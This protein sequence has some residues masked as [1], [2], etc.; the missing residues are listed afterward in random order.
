VDVSKF[1]KSYI[2]KGW[3]RRK[4]FDVTSQHQTLLEVE[5]ALNNTEILYSWPA[6]N[7]EVYHHNEA[8]FEHQEYGSV[9]PPLRNESTHGSLPWLA[10]QREIARLVFVSIKSTKA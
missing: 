6:A 4:M 5:D 8:P 7:L 10:L 3:G 2:L 1:G 9:N